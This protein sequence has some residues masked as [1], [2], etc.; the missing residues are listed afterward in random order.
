MPGGI[1]GLI[2]TRKPAR[3]PARVSSTRLPACTF[4]LRA[5]SGC[6]ASEGSAMRSARAGA[7]ALSSSLPKICH[8]GR[9][10]QAPSRR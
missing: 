2:M 7:S 9:I 1:A 4:S 6:S 5:S 10:S 8:K 3:P